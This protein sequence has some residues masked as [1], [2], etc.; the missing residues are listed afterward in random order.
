MKNNDRVLKADEEIA[1]FPHDRFLNPIYLNT[2]ESRTESGAID[3]LVIDKCMHFIPYVR[4]ERSLR[5][6]VSPP[7]SCSSIW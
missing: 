6:P 1:R 2:H 3:S 5:R 4:F 7:D